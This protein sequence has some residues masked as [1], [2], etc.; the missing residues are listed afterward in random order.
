MK[1]LGEVKQAFVDMWNGIPS[2]LGAPGGWDYS[3]P[4]WWPNRAQSAK[5][6][7]VERRTLPAGSEIVTIQW[8]AAQITL[9]PDEARKLAD[10]IR[11]V[12]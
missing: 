4:S 7:R 5:P 3:K 12:L 9:D 10:A 2:L 1:L 6:P 11:E 8:G